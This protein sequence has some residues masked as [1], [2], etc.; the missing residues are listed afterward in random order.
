MNNH[1][2]STEHFTEQ[3]PT[4]PI[5]EAKNE[6]SWI[7]FLPMILRGLGALA[8]LVSLYTFLARGWDASTD[9]TRY[10]IFIGHTAALA[11]V[12]L[13]N[14]KI[15]KEAKGARLLLI[16]ALASIPINFAILGGFIFAGSHIGNLI[17]YP[18]YV[19]WSVGSIDTALLLTGSA[20]MVM[21]PVALL[22]FKV[23]VRNVAFK[24]SI[25]F[26]V[27]NLVLLIP[28]RQPE[29]VAILSALIGGGLLVFYSVYL[30]KQL[31]LKTLEG[32]IAFGLRF[33]PVAIL[34]GRSFWLYQFD[35]ILISSTSLVLFIAVRQVSLLLSENTFKRLSL[36]LTSILL[37]ILCS[38]SFAYWLMSMDVV[39]ELII[40]LV[41]V[42]SAGM[43]FDLS[44]RSEH[45]ASVYRVL[46]IVI[47]LTGLIINFWLFTS[48]LSALILIVAGTAMLIGSFVFQQ[49][50][51]FIG[52]LILVVAGL[53]YLLAHLMTF[54]QMNYWIALT[55]LGI[56]SIVS[57]S[58]LEANSSRIKIWLKQSKS[59]LGKW[60]Y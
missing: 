8:V 15:I 42:V 60:E 39:G 22:G 5:V 37:T 2:D 6:N 19:T 48:L 11:L 17:E 40:A 30:K 27:S 51:L 31:I 9:V 14:A 16:L 55:G 45:R 12:G 18:Q 38:T 28:I 53:Y 43:I 10:L 50:A 3:I 1:I 47:T 54:F 41:T 36:E 7:S 57:G 58:Y 13:I 56:L 26:L 23:L 29:L 44:L 32:K 34:L 4:Q 46:S 25:V 24:T 52:G 20:L 49:K 21:I 59:K 33:L 35:S